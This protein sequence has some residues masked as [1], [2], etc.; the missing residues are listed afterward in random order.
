MSDQRR[1]TM[2]EAE[3]EALCVWLESLAGCNFQQEIP[4]ESESLTWTCD[5]TIKLTHH[6]M[7]AHGVN[8]EAILPKLED[9]GG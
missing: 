7:A 4:G 3:F 2:T 9:Q 8:E 5:G 6:W 1:Q